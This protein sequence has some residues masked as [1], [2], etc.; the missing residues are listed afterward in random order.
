MNSTAFSNKIAI[1]IA[2]PNSSPKLA[3][4]NVANHITKML[5][6]RYY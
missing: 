4:Y 6:R 3:T 2:I 5:K 1:L